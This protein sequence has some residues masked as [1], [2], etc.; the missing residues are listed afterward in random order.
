MSEE[1]MELLK[2]IV[3]WKKKEAEAKE[4]VGKYKGEMLRLME[5]EKIVVVSLP[6]VGKARVKESVRKSIDYDG[7]RKYL[8][9]VGVAPATVG[10]AFS[11]NT[12]ESKSRYIDVRME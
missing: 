4:M 10:E 5:Q 8:V 1:V 11:E 6:G 12:R 7:V 3:Q 2:E 9:G